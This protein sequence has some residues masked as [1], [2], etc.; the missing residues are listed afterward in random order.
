MDSECAVCYSAVANCTLVCKHA[1]CKD[2]VKEW[3]HKSDDPTC[4]MCRRAMYFKGMYKVAET[5]EQERND[6]KN[7]DVF[8]EAFEAIFEGDEFSSDEDTE[9]DAESDV[10]WETWGGSQMDELDVA[11]D[12]V[13]SL[14]IPITTPL[15]SPP[16]TTDYY[17]E[18][19]LQEIMELQ[20]D[21]QKA[22]DIGMDFDVYLENLEY[23]F[24]ET[25]KSGW[26][27]DDNMPKNLFVSKHKN[28]IRNKRLGKRIPSKNDM[29]STIVVYVLC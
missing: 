16:S 15:W 20:K 23:V 11:T 8:N 6:K 4:P 12:E 17:S 22:M 28:M 18:F 24:I 3:Y 13:T 10:S 2:C 29:G 1:F 14:E 19:L 26:T 21:Y 25:V 5:W 27:E 7:E 9:S